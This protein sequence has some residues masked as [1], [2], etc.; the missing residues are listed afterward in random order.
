MRV[1]MYLSLLLYALFLLLLNKGLEIQ[2]K[3]V[4]LFFQW[5]NVKEKGTKTLVYMMQKS[6]NDAQT[7]RMNDTQTDRMNDT[8]TDKM[9]DKAT[10]PTSF[11]RRSVP[12]VKHFNNKKNMQTQYAL[13]KKSSDMKPFSSFDSQDFSFSVGDIIAIKVVTLLVI[14]SS[15]VKY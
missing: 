2:K 3:E 11:Q 7:D 5:K 15:F 9:N 10:Y 4:V 6:R 8:Q 13:K 1:S 12:D 14:H